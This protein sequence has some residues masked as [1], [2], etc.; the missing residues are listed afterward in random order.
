[1]GMQTAHNTIEKW[2]TTAFEFGWHGHREE[3]DYPVVSASPK[4]KLLAQHAHVQQPRCDGENDK[5]GEANIGLWRSE[6]STARIFA[7]RTSVEGIARE[8]Y[9]RWSNSQR[10]SAKKDHGKWF[11]LR[12]IQ[13]WLCSG[14]D[15]GKR[16]WTQCGDEKFDEE[17]DCAKDMRV[18]RC[19]SRL[20]TRSMEGWDWFWCTLLDMRE[21]SV[22]CCAVEW[23]SR[24]KS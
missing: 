3:D 23:C 7:S 10:H 13:F 21:A 9:E 11:W 18:Q 20:E 17:I 5:G 6:F 14:I 19:L 12:Q 1:M 4:I 2:T 16:R 15:W 24:P 8:G 22:R